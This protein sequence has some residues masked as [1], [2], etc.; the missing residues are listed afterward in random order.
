MLPELAIPLPELFER[1]LV[2][3]HSKAGNFRYWPRLYK[4][5]RRDSHTLDSFGCL[6]EIVSELHIRAPKTRR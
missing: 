4:N 5:S 2:G 1:P 6:E 3:G